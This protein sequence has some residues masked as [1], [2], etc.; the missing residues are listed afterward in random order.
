MEKLEKVVTFDE[1]ITVI[2]QIAWNFAY[3]QARQKYWEYYPLDRER[4]R[5][6]R[7]QPM[8]EKLERVYSKKHGQE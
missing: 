6:Y 3:R 1:N 2:R 4:F 7:I 8:E 5:H